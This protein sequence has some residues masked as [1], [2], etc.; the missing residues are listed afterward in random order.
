MRKQCSSILSHLSSCDLG[1]M[2]QPGEWGRWIPDQVRKDTKGERTCLRGIFRPILCNC[3]LLLTFKP[4]NLSY[5]YLSR[6]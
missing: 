2:S 6:V 1:I 5:F 3:N 4:E